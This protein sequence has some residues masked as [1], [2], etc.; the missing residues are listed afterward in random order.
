VCLI[1]FFVEAT[2][3][4]VGRQRSMVLTTKKRYYDGYFQIQNLLKLE[5]LKGYVAGHDPVSSSSTT[6]ELV[7]KANILVN[8]L[9]ITVDVE[10]N[11]LSGSIGNGRFS[12]FLPQRNILLCGTAVSCEKRKSV[13]LRDG[14]TS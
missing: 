6:F 11:L 8:M 4:F 7:V 12:A 3:S 5:A 13:Q 9:L 2:I 10:Q 14:S 1:C